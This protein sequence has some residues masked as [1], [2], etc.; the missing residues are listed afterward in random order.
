[1]KQIPGKSRKR[2]GWVKAIGMG[3][4]MAIISWG[5]P[6]SANIGPGDISG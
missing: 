3:L 6:L 5:T 1:M 4:G 2:T